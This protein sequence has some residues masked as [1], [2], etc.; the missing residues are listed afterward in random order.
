[1]SVLKMNFTFLVSAANSVEEVA[2][3]FPW[4]DST[5]LE[6]INSYESEL[7]EQLSQISVSWNNVLR[8]MDFLQWTGFPQ[9]PLGI[10]I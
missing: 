7:E 5:K 10:F 6:F 3:I 2:N 4:D 8:A 1:M 9:F